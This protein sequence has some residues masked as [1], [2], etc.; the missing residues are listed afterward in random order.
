MLIKH[1]YY[2]Y[3][4]VA[5]GNDSYVDT[6]FSSDAD[7]SKEGYNIKFIL[8]AG[9]NNDT[10]NNLINEGKILFV[11]H[12]ECPQ[13][14][15][16]TVVTSNENEKVFIVHESK[17]NGTVQICTM[18]VAMVDISGYKNEAFSSDYRGF[19][20]NIEKGCVLGI[21]Q[22]IN[23]DINK[24]KED[25]ENTASIFSIV[26]IFDPEAT[27]M[28]VNTNDKR[29][30]IIK[31]PEK[32][33]NRYKNL[34]MNLELQPVM[35]S[36]IIIPALIQVFNELKMHRSELY[37]Y[38]EYKWFKGLKKACKK[39]DKDLDENSLDAIDSY[40]IAQLL[41]DSPTIK[42]LKFLSECNG[43]DVE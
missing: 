42:A 17:L 38:E 26:P 7:I 3:P 15:Y 6:V 23:V 41:M 22:Q 40:E 11:H 14:C 36:M 31:I 28:L 4:V 35:H 5:E 27:V 20:F 33:Y 39:I 18:L 30:I 13:T 34:S 9:I 8:K 32:T 25:L 12:I 2:P 37:M 10:I 1:K 43:G 16:R 19:G 29:K 24:E 21:G